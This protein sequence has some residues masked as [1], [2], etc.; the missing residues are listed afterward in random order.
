MWLN[1]ASRK[2]LHD[3]FPFVGMDGET[4]KS[5]LMEAIMDKKTMIEKLVRDK[6]DLPGPGCTQKKERS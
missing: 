1:R 4:N 2:R 3:K 6:P 5:M